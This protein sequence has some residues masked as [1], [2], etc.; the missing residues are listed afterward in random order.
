MNKIQSIRFTTLRFVKLSTLIF[1]AL[2]L[3]SSCDMFDTI[4]DNSDDDIN[5]EGPEQ[6]ELGETTVY[7]VSGNGEII[8]EDTNT[9]YSFL[10]PDGGLGT[11]EVGN[12]ISGPETPFDGKGI[13]VDYDGNENL[14]I[15]I[16]NTESKYDMVLGYGTATG[17]MNDSID[18]DPRWISVALTDS[19]D[20][21][22]LFDLPMPFE[23]LLKGKDVRR[24]SH[25]G[26]SHYLITSN[27]CG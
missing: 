2:F 9:G 13:Y 25:R 6:W 27:P 22:L 3:F 12:I 8:V 17:S 14:Q 19:I 10:F 18:A 23:E 16:P 11:L 1:V 26:F 7:D 4:F 5:T 20:G 24:T 15:I 21:Y